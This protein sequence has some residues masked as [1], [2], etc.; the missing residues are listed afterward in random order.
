MASTQKI[1][2]NYLVFDDEDAEYEL[3]RTEIKISGMECNVIFL[4]PGIY[5]CPVEDKFDIERF[6]EDIIEKTQGLQIHLV[7]S[8]WNMLA[9]TNNYPEVNA[10]QII[11]ILLEIHNKYKK[12]NYLIYSGKPNEVSTVLIDKIKVELDEKNE[13][14]YSKELLSLLLELKIKFSSRANRFMEIITLINSA[15]TISLIVLN[16]LSL[17]ENNKFHNTGNDFFDGKKIEELLLLISENNDH[18]LKFVREFVDMSI[19]H[20]TLLNE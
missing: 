9:A 17:F 1:P 5:Y 18:G 4:N 12:V 19:A 14:I 8:D 20:Y 11:Q 6:K 13:P 15:K 7:A 2:L 16:S 3:N 10:L